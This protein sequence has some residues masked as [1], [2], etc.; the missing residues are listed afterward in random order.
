MIIVSACLTGANCT[1]KG[2]NNL[3]KRLKD[4]VEGGRAVPVCPEELGGLGTP[5]HRAEIAG[6]DGKD[7]LAGRARV[8]SAA[9]RDVTK[10]YI[11]GARASL[12]KAREHGVKL[13]VFKSN[14]P[15]CGLGRIYDGTF[16]KKMKR[17]NGVCAQLFLDSGI[18]VMTERDL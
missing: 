7:V 2:G 13:A 8:L 12:K 10:N 1:Y 9:G 4:M 15:A 3:D 14:S 6:G 18:F 11:A 16:G 17:G 5:R